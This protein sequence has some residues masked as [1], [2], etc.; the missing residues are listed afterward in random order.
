MAKLTKDGR[1][2]QSVYGGRHGFRVCESF[3]GFG[4][5]S[6]L[7]AAVYARVSSED[8]Q[9]RGTIEAQVDFARRYCELHDIAPLDWYL[10]DGVSG[11]VALDDRPAGHRLLQDARAKRFEQVLV[12]RLDR[13]ARSTLHLLRAVEELD[14]HGVALRSMTEEFNSATPTGR[15][16]LTTLG[17]IAELERATITERMGQGAIRAIRQ[18]KHVGGPVPYGYTLDG[19]GRLHPDDA[20][21]PGMPWSE[22]D[23]ARLIFAELAAGATTISVGRRLSALGVP[24]RVKYVTHGGQVTIRSCGPL[25]RPGRVRNIVRN[26][27]Y[28]GEY[29]NRGVSAT[30]PA[31][32]TSDQWAEANRVLR[33]NRSRPSHQKRLYTLSGLLR[34]GLC[35]SAYVGS[36]GDWPRYR[37]TSYL[38]SRGFYQPRCGGKEIGAVSTERLAWEEAMKVIRGER[39]GAGPG[40]DD[41]R[42]PPPLR[43]AIA[44]AIRQKAVER[45]RVVGLYRRSLLTDVQ[46]EVQLRQIDAE[47]GALRAELAGLVD[48]GPAID[49]ET[50]LA[51]ARELSRDGADAE[52]RRKVL[53]LLLHRVV[54][55][56]RKGAGRRVADLEFV[57]RV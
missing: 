17:S 43:D 13:L 34:C 18:G 35:G 23:V 4:Y 31:L 27:I 29:V 14:R 50:I 51:S 16:V 21:I 53:R 45:D 40:D 33:A 54:V 19:E 25:W 5:G 8:Q 52:T 37:C 57:W 49:A 38:T 42:E 20:P 56:T 7:K 36:G 32:V 39:P 3:D 2:R 6:T 26:P 24:A 11:A 1:R 10:D 22:P 28:Q 15:F 9:E 47:E 55:H 44:V 48:A 30:C 41:R 46:V 12:Y